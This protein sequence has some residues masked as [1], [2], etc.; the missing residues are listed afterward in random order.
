[1]T[2]ELQAKILKVIDDSYERGY[3]ITSR[4]IAGH[5]Q[6]KYGSVKACLRGMVGKEMVWGIY[7]RDRDI[8][9]YFPIKCLQRVREKAMAEG[10]TA[11][12]Q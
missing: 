11:P 8:T 12:S 1:M 9:E 6:V 7:N 3:H 10:Q 2:T 5:I 4:Q